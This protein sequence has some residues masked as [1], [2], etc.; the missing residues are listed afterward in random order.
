[1]DHPG[2][3]EE[4]Y[5]ELA[6]RIHAKD[7]EGVRRVFRKLLD[8]GRSRQEIVS[9]IVRLIDARPPNVAGNSDKG[10]V[11]RRA[12]EQSQTEWRR[13]PSTWPDSAAR[14][15]AGQQ[16]FGV[17]KIRPKPEPAQPASAPAQRASDTFRTPLTRA[18][19]TSPK[20]I[21]QA[22]LGSS[23]ENEE[24]RGIGVD[25][26]T[27][28]PNAGGGLAASSESEAQ[29]AGVLVEAERLVPKLDGEDAVDH[30]IASDSSQE[31]P[32]TFVGNA[33]P[34]QASV[35]SETAQLTV[36]ERLA[37]RLRLQ[38]APA[39]S[40]TAKQKQTVQERADASSE[41]W[42]GTPQRNRRASSRALRVLTGASIFTAAAGGFHVGWGLYGSK[43]EGSLSGRAHSAVAWFQHLLSKDVSSTLEPVTTAQKT[44]QPNKAAA[45]HDTDDQVTN[46]R[47]EKGEAS[48]VR[49]QAEASSIVTPGAGVAGP[50]N[51][52]AEITPT[53]NSAPPRRIVPPIPQGPVSSGTPMTTAQDHK[54]DARQSPTTS[55]ATP[56]VSPMNTTALLARGDQL[57]GAS[58][59]ASARLFYERA[60]EAG[61]ARGALRMGMTFD[62][63]FLARSGLLRVQ[64]DPDQAI[65]WYRRASA[66]GNS[67]AEALERE[68][69]DVAQQI[70]SIRGAAVQVPEPRRVAG[71][72]RHRAAD[73]AHQVRSKRAP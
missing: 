16:G 56:D 59:I 63:D 29:T 55:A 68:I 48:P 27:C 21:D 38:E 13:K 57:L 35:N 46:L 1:V 58:D 25:E 47:Q 8:T 28:A 7:D 19:E 32:D 30:E 61:D 20:Q 37:A 44:L 51:P 15:G 12:F 39:E 5:D 62:M 53:R 70:Q 65:S 26:I 17:E 64:G 31:H 14:N 6:K 3:V 42:S 24:H 40:P 60:A 18:G 49:P 10:R 71:P 45:V 22:G 72:H 50:S 9:E 4:L 54:A 52:D 23:P 2:N 69:Q 36:P 67:K 66:L 41:D 73:A 34:R 33:T 11:A 43:L